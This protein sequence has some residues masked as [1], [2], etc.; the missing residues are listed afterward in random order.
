MPA[1]PLLTPEAGASPTP[2]ADCVSDR[3]AGA[4]ARPEAGL[5]AST[6]G[7]SQDSLTGRGRGA[8]SSA[9]GEP[10]HLEGGAGPPPMTG[11]SQTPGAGVSDPEALF[12]SDREAGE[13]RGWVADLPSLVA[14]VA[15]VRAPHQKPYRLSPKA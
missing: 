9:A 11:A 10:L 4:S 12:M 14:A 3:E 6:T 8:G 13:S 1:Y 2:E 5:E 15:L 7:P